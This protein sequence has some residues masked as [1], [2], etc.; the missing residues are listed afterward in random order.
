MKKRKNRQGL[1]AENKVET[2]PTGEYQT[3]VIDPPWSIERV[4]LPHHVEI[5]FP[6]QAM[7]YR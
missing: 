4:S 7:R 2:T 3:I 5:A 6:Y 1:E